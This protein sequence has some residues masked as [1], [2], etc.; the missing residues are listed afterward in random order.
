[1]RY[2]LKEMNCVKFLKLRTQTQ[3]KQIL[4][5]SNPQGE[6]WKIPTNRSKQTT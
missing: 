2:L 1:M 4:I 5:Y 6:I 3:P